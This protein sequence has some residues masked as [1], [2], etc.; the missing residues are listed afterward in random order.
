MFPAVNQLGRGGLAA[1]GR[2]HISPARAEAGWC[3]GLHSPGPEAF[4][5]E[6]RGKRREI[7]GSARWPVA[8]FSQG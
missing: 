5:L 7:A 2:S 8:R 3:E 6:S 4:A 1:G